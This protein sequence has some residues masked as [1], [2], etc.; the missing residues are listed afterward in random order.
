MGGAKAA[1]TA[2]TRARRL[3]RIG[4][5]RWVVYP[6]VRSADPETTWPLQTKARLHDLRTS[7]SNLKREWSP[8]AMSQSRRQ[9]RLLHPQRVSGVACFAYRRRSRRRRV[10]GGW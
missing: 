8:D 1:A 4:V 2:A 10:Y 9:Q 6:G 5:L 7:P 3:T